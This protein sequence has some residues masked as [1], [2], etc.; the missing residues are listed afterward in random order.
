M[1]FNLINCFLLLIQHLAGAGGADVLTQLLCN[2]DIHHSGFNLVLP[3][4][5]AQHSRGAIM[6]N[7]TSPAA[8]TRTRTH[9]SRA[10]LHRRLQVE[11]LLSRGSKQE[12]NS[13]TAASRSSNR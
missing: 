2:V 10:V 3:H 4:E 1:L 5:E 13:C 6:H 8:H 9:K 7:K 12:M 11:T